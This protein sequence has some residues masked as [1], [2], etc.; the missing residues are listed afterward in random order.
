LGSIGNILVNI[1]PKW[2]SK[3]QHLNAHHSILKVTPAICTSTQDIYPSIN[4]FYVLAPK[5]MDNY[6][7]LVEIS[8]PYK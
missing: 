5:E 6:K 7:E 3:F 4:N 1:I 8:S 2:A